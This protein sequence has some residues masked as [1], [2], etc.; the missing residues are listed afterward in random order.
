MDDEV[1]ICYIATG[2]GLTI[3]STASS[4]EEAQNLLEERDFLNSSLAGSNFY[5]IPAKVFRGADGPQ[6]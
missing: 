1:L 3:L 4:V 2:M 5:L 6:T